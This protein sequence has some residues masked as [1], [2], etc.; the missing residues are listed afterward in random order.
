[1]RATRRVGHMS[2]HGGCPLALPISGRTFECPPT[3]VNCAWRSIQQPL[4]RRLEIRK[5]LDIYASITRRHQEKP[6][7]VYSLWRLNKY[8]FYPIARENPRF[9]RRKKF[10]YNR[11]FSLGSRNVNEKFIVIRELAML[12][13]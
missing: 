11:G 5:R 3:G 7:W 4:F 6:S 10:F 8:D 2:Q 9:F 12:G 13:N 1:R